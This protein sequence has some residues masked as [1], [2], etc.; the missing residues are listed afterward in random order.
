MRTKSLKLDTIIR[1]DRRKFLVGGGALVAFGLPRGV[2]AQAEMTHS[3]MQGAV[4]VTVLNDGFLTMPG[5]VIGAGAPQEEFMAFMER[6]FG[7]LPET[8]DFPLNVTLLRT[9]EDVILVDNGS[10]DKFQPSAG[11]LMANLALNGVDP[12][13]VT[14]VVVTH[15]HPDHI[16]GTLAADGAHNFP[17]AAYYIGSTEL[18]FWMNPDIFNILP[19]DAHP[20]AK[21][22]QRDLAAVQDRLTVVKD[23]D[24]IAPGISVI[25]TPGHTPGHISVMVEDGGGLIIVGDAIPSEVLHM[26]HPEWTTAFDGDPEMTGKTRRRLLDQATADG[27]RLLGFHF[28]YPGVGNVEKSGDGYKFTPLG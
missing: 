9:N 12:E 17:N 11:R 2:L 14:K 16:W 24:T 4:E 26:A 8:I 1:L 22:A 13:D 7:G 15:A 3:H 27:Y 19:S 20:F 6:A 21:G 18:D 25:D 28:T 5:G 10:G 23:G